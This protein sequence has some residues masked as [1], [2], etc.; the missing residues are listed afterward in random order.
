MSAS[1]P[2]YLVRFIIAHYLSL[3]IHLGALPAHLTSPPLHHTTPAGTIIIS[4][5]LAV[6]SNFFSEEYIEQQR[7]AR[8]QRMLAEFNAKM[9]DPKSIE[10]GEFSITTSGKYGRTIRRRLSSITGIGESSKALS[11]IKKEWQ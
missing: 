5:P 11:P 3:P 10:K 8:R 6:I 9:N 2:L 4:L 1:S 7:I